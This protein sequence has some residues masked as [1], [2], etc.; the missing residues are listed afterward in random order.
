MSAWRLKRLEV[1]LI[2]F[3]DW[4]AN[5]SY[6]GF[7]RDAQVV[8]WFWD[9]INNSSDDHCRLLLQFVTGSSSVPFGGFSKLGGEKGFIIS[10]W[11]GVSDRLPGAS[12]C[13]NTLK[14]PEYRDAQTLQAMIARA[15]DF[16]CHGFEFG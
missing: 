3:A 1:N 2:T 16:G 13:F 8:Q 5:T 15:L 4:K 9:F 11:V 14:L 12:T 7:D 10:R 6:D